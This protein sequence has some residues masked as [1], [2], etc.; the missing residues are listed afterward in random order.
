MAE[1]PLRGPAVIY[2]PFL[3]EKCY[4]FHLPMQVQDYPMYLVSFIKKYRFSQAGL[5][6]I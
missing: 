5:S 1:V 4:A 6:L 2:I 3:D